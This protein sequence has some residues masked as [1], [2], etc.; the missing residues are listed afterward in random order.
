MQK[1]HD[2]TIEQVEDRNRHDPMADARIGSVSMDPAF[3][4]F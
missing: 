4:G 1:D 3:V 2:S